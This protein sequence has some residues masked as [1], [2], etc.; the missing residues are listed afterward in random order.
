MFQHRWMPVKTSSALINNY[1]KP[2]INLV[3]KGI[4]LLNAVAHTKWFNTAIETTGVIEDELSLCGNRHHPKGGKQIYCFC[5]A[6]KGVKP[7]IKEKP[8]FNYIDYAED[9]LK[10]KVTRS[11]AAQL[12]VTI[13]ISEK[14]EVHTCKRKRP[15]NQ[16]K[17]ELGLNSAKPLGESKVTPSTLRVSSSK[18]SPTSVHPHPPLTMELLYWNSMEAAKLFLPTADE[19]NCL[20]AI[21]NQISVLKYAMSTLLS[22]LTVV[23][24]IGEPVGD[25]SELLTDYQVWVIRQKCQILLCILNITRKKMPTIQNWDAVCLC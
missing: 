7:I 9:L 17:C 13:P 18:P 2:P 15:Q 23:D 4:K 19:E 22:Y 14:D 10:T 1:Y 6:P 12:N 16:E 21:E 11:N 8:W 5:A 24:C 20:V 3:C 25:P